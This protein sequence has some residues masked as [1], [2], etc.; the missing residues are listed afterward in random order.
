MSAVPRF[1]VRCNPFDALASCDCLWLITPACVFSVLAAFEVWV[2]LAVLAPVALVVTQLLILS[3]CDVTRDASTVVV[4][5]PFHT[6]T[7]SMPL[8]ARVVSRSSLSMKGSE[9]VQVTDSTGRRIW[10]AASLGLTVR[11]R[12][13]VCALLN[14]VP[15][16]RLER[17]LGAWTLRYQV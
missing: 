6:Y 10:V 13:L 5:N 2:V 9:L 17:D 16:K 8:K 4:R 3:R 15:A 1:R 14:G 12:L 7:L 11:R